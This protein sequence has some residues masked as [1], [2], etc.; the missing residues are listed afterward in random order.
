M[1]MNFGILEL[2]LFFM[3]VKMCALENIKIKY[4]KWR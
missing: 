1:E 2:S 4:E 3:Y